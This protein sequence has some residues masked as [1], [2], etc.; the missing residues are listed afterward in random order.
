MLPW[1]NAFAHNASQ[2]EY[3]CHEEPGGSNR[4]CHGEYQKWLDLYILGGVLVLA[5]VGGLIISVIDGLDDSNAF[6][7]LETDDNGTITPTYDVE[8]GSVGI[9]YKLNF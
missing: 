6:K 7:E 4:H 3:T 9:R 1:T 8:S 2:N 5:I